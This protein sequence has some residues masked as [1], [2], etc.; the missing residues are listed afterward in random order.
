MSLNINS[1]II[2][3]SNWVKL[4]GIRIDSRLNFEP[5]VSNLCKSAARQLHALLRLK[6]YLTFEARKILIESFPYSNFNYYFLVWN[7]TSVKV[8]NEI[9]SV[10]KSSPR[11]LFDEYEF[12]TK[13]LLLLDQ[14]FGILFLLILRPQN[15]LKCLKNSSK[16]GTE[17]CL[18]AVCAH[19]IRIIKSCENK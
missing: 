18:S 16:H 1:N 5:H 2:I 12:G 9:E 6:S 11:F 7:F 14:K 19:I 4:L 15:Y 10:Q 8:I 3:S 13:V 17:K